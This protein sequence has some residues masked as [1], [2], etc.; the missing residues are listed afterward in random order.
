M[1]V[2]R[3]NND[4]SSSPDRHSSGQYDKRKEEEKESIIDDVGTEVKEENVAVVV[5]DEGD[6]EKNKDL[7]V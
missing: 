1:V 7:Q 2:N 6:E 3:S 4:R 5:D